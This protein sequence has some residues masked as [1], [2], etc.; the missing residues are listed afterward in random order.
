M[1]AGA[2]I[3]FFAFLPQVC[4]VSLE[5]GYGIDSFLPF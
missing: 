4:V 3:S 1:E 2:G 5:R